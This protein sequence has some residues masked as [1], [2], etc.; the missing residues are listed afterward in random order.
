MLAEKELSRVREQ[1]ERLM[2]QM[3]SLQDRIAFS[4][5]YVTLYSQSVDAPEDPSPGFGEVFGFAF[6]ALAEFFRSLA[7]VGIWMAVWAVV[8]LPVTLLVWWLLRK[9]AQRTAR[10]EEQAA[11]RE[12]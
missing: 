3:R 8:W 1:S 12:Y 10:D 4:T 2:A 5:I 6:E 11:N 9:Q 7:T